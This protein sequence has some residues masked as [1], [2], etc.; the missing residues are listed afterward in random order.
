MSR[1]KVETEVMSHRVFK[2][3]I[4]WRRRQKNALFFLH[5]LEHRLNEI[6]KST[7]DDECNPV[8]T[9]VLIFHAS[10]INTLFSL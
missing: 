9:L 7:V 4:V 5:F 8:F 6:H 10:S 1:M 3:L 2:M